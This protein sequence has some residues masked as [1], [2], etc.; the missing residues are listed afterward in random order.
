MGNY[1]G[2]IAGLLGLATTLC[3]CPTKVYVPVYSCPAPVLGTDPI[4]PIENVKENSSFGELITLYSASLEACKGRVVE[5][6]TKL[7][8]YDQ[9]KG[10]LPEP[11]KV[12]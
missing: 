2:K 7:G 11:S 1:T 9:Y 5:L 4:L 3:G 6:K 10:S 8:A 12:E